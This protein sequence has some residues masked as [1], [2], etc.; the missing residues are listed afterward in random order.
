[1]STQRNY[2]RNHMFVPA[3]LAGICL[4][5]TGSAVAG[6]GQSEISKYI[7]GHLVLGTRTAYRS[8]TDGDS[9][10]KGGTYGSGTFLGTIY[11][12]DINEDY[13]PFRLFATYYFNQFFGIEL[14]YDY[15][16]DDSLAMDIPYTY[17]E[18]TDGSIEIS[19]PT[20]SLIGRY[21][22]YDKLTPFVGFGLG[23]FSTSFDA[24]PEWATTSSRNR[25]RTM[26][27]DDPL[28][29]LWTAGLS[30][31]FIPHWN[32]DFSFQYM[33]NMDVDAAFIGYTD[34]VQDTYQTGHFP[35][36]NWAL[37][38]GISYSF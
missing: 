10:H 29:L 16:E 27:V 36:D 20:L 14:A 21:P 35:L 19:G 37:R 26:V 22:L 38:L 8:L 6:I 5:Y 9:G 30:W 11:G 28:A 33:S 2:L 7:N 17:K 12:L 13:T 32:A 25:V 18:K 31:E 3:F 24:T 4:F 34:G 23:F 1:M 15:M